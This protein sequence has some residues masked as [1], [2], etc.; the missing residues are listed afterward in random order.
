LNKKGLT[1]TLGILKVMVQARKNSTETIWWERAGRAI[2]HCIGRKSRIFHAL[3]AMGG[4]CL[5]DNREEL[6]IFI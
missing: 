2:L 6:S 4:I 1:K 5:L 3:S